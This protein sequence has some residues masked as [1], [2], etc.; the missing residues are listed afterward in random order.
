MTMAHTLSYRVRNSSLG[1]CLFVLG[2]LCAGCADD[3]TTV[4][5]TPPAA[6]GSGVPIRGTERLGWDQAAPSYSRVR[7]YTFTIFIDGTVAALPG[8]ECVES[9]SA[10]GFAC[11]APVPQMSTGTHTIQLAASVDGVESSRSSPLVV[12]V[13]QGRIVVGTQV[14]TVTAAEAARR[15]EQNSFCLDSARGCFSLQSEVT[16]PVRIAA[17]ALLP[18]GRLLFVED[19]RHIRMVSGGDLLAEPLFS[20]PSE[21]SRAIALM[22]DGDFERSRIVRVAWIDEEAGRRTFA[23]TRLRESNNR[24][25]EAV[26]VVPPLPLGPAADPAVAQ[27]EKG[28][29]YVAIPGLNG[30]TAGRDVYAAA[31]LR[32]SP[33]GSTWTAGLGSPIFSAGF[34]EPRALAVDA[35]QRLWLAGS[36]GTSE[37]LVK[38]LVL[39][40][41]PQATAV[42]SDQASSQ[43]GS[44]AVALAAV[45]EHV[46]GGLIG[47]DADGALFLLRAEG[48]IA[49]RSQIHG[50][51]I[52]GVHASQGAILL[53]ATSAASP[54]RHTIYRLIPQKSR[55][56]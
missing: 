22:V 21:R 48:G 18:D 33:D 49:A 56:H 47:A 27:D 39:R 4:D 38:A 32:F 7:Q 5:V 1:V 44:R 16:R 6:P 24:F 2:A 26:V 55:S 15:D 53:T 11:S 40:D 43:E 35:R 31:I 46:G 42:D 50:E 20:L 34:L 8:V 54:A 25:G 13:N 14:D 12:A 52:V 23:V 9:S 37:N 41:G 29:M 28:L 3:G 36:N 30:T 10:S 51:R 19:D 17:P 45:P